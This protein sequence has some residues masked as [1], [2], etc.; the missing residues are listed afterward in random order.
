MTD[1]PP[2]SHP[3]PQAVD[4]NPVPIGPSPALVV[5]DT[6]FSDTHYQQNLYDDFAMDALPRRNYAMILFIHPKN[7]CVDGDTGLVSPVTGIIQG[8]NRS[9]DRPAS[10]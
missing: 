1:L 2:I 6:V 7:Q 4:Q 8:E 10:D 3:C 5:A 9:D